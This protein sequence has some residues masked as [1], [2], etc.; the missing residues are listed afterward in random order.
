MKFSLPVT[1]TR[2]GRGENQNS[3]KENFK[4]TKNLKKNTEV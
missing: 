3:I 2:K 4:K 1:E